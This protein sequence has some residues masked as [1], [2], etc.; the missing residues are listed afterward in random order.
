MLVAGGFGLLSS[1]F[2]W[3]PPPYSA[4][5]SSTPLVNPPPL[6]AFKGESAVTAMEVIAKARVPIIKLRFHNLQVSQSSA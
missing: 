2:A 1:C 5:P 3:A 6:K 4:H